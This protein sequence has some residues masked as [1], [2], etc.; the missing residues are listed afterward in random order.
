[1]AQENTIDVVSMT[2]PTSMIDLSDHINYW[3]FGYPAVMVTDT[4]DYRNHNYHKDTDTIGTLD[5][6]SMAGVVKGVY[7]VIMDY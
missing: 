3:Y 4:A 7:K 6:T 2:A 1:M 5:F